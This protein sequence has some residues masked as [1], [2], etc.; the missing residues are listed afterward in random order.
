MR[1]TVWLAAGAVLGV[2]GYR[3][4]DRAVRSITGTPGPAPAPSVRQTAGGGAQG[5]GSG[6]RPAVA[7][8]SAALWT[9]R[10]LRAARGA[11]QVIGA[12]VGTFLA[13]VRTGMAE[14]LDVH[15]QN[16]NRQHTGSGSTLID[17]TRPRVV[18]P[19]RPAGA[20]GSGPGEF[21][22]AARKTH[23]IKDGR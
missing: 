5:E 2:V 19:A 9:A 8:L 15:E 11:S 7:A 22:A 23:E 18:I 13:E 20:L 16:M 3:R 14:Y 6:Q 12:E 1:R 4:L 21:G 10:Q 17:Q